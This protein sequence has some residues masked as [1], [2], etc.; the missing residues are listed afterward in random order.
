[1]LDRTLKE[2]SSNDNLITQMEFTEALSGLSKDTVSGPD[3]VKCSDRKN[4]P[5]DDTSKLFT[6]CEESF[7][8][9]QVPRIGHLASSNQC[10]NQEN[11]TAS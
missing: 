1:M 8:T 4:L 3:K 6:L 2:A 7:A 5:E 11:T 9:G 10:P